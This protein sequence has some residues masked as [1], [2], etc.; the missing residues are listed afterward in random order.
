METLYII[1]INII[2]SVFAFFFTY[3]IIPHL[4]SMFIGANLYGKD[5]NKKSENKIPEA[6]GVVT[7]CTFLITIFVL[8]PVIFGRHMLQNDT[9][10][11]P[12]SEF[13]E[14]LA[15]LLSICCMLL[16]GFADDVLNLRW[17]HKLLLPTIASL[18]LLV[19]YYINFNSTTIIVPKPFRDIFGVSVNLGLLYYVYMGMLAV[20]CTNAI[21]ILA[22]INGLETGQSLIIAISI[23]IFNLIELSGDCGQAHLFSLHFI[24][25]FI[26]VTFALL[27][28]NWYPSEV[29]VGDTYC[30][31]AGMTFAVVGILGHFSKTMLLFFLPQIFN[32]L[33]SIP[34]LFHFINCPRHRIPRLDKY[35]TLSPSYAECNNNNISPIG[36]MCLKV[37]SIFNIINI[38]EKADGIIKCNNLTLINL[39]LLKMGPTNEKTLTITLLIVQF[40]CSLFAFIIRYPL[41]S[42]FYDV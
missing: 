8:I 38:E 1:S 17:R 14:M 15:A 23:V 3:N 10:L 24:I 26:S 30:Y 22:G 34:Q 37:F 13:V 18:P 32:F 6:F 16:L 35:G 12:H 9:T 39:C 27:K 21:N 11:F 31:F 28:Y 41:A 42:L 7:G 4:K 5:L 29:F 36:K 33:Y 2:L 19:V 40:V 25:P 20:F